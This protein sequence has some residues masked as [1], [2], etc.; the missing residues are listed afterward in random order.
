MSFLDFFGA[1]YAL[2]ALV[3]TASIAAFAA[4]AA[5]INALMGGIVSAL[6]DWAATGAYFLPGNLAACISA[7]MTAKIGR[8]AYDFQ[9]S[10]LMMVGNG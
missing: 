2:K 1:R 3:I 7:L 8:W 6:P 4:L 10:R 9:R 5:A